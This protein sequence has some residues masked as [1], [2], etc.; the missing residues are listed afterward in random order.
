MFYNPFKTNKVSNSEKKIRQVSDSANNKDPKMIS[1]FGGLATEFTWRDISPRATGKIKDQGKTCAASYAFAVVAAVEAAQAIELGQEYN[2]LSEQQL[3]DCTFD[4]NY[5]N[6]G[7]LGGHL[8][9]SLTY[10]KNNKIVDSFAY[11]YK[12]EAQFCKDLKSAPNQNGN[13]SYSINGFK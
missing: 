9:S 10:A 12:G 8:N 6:F 4:H 1:K 7:C 13:H 11:P 3:V 5:Q 2:H